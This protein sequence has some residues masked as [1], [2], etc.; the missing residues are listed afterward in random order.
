MFDHRARGVRYLFRVAVLFHRANSVWNSFGAALFHHRASCVSHLLGAA[1]LHVAGTG[2]RNLFG[3]GARNA[4]ANRV[5]NLAVLHFLDVVRTGNAAGDRFRAPN[6]AADG[7][8]GAL[9]FYRLAATGLVHATAAVFIPF[10]CSRFAN[11]FFN[12]R[13]GA[14]F[15]HRLP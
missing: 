15:S 14:M 3:G 6:F 8:A 12:N 10:P 2:V 4:F 11:T 13:S 1:F 9:H 5:R 7:R